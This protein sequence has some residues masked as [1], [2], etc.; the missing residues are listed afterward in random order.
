MRAIRAIQLVMVMTA[1]VVL[2]ADV[3]A[4]DGALKVSPADE[5]LVIDPSVDS[6]ER[7]TPQFV[8][9]TTPGTQQ[10]EIPPTVIIHRYYYTGNRSFQG[11]ML[12]GGPSV[13]VLNHPRTGEQVSVQAQ[14]LP[15]APRVK[16]TADGISYDYGDREICLVFSLLGGCEPKIVFQR[17]PAAAG[18]LA[19]SVV[20]AQ[21]RSHEF[22]RRTGLPTLLRNARQ[23]THDGFMALGDRINDLGP[24]MIQR[25]SSV[26]D[27]SPATELLT[28]L[29]E[30]VVNSPASDDLTGIVNELRDTVPAL[31]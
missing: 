19:E 14:L 30:G 10:I 1:A 4:E 5:L 9:G 27:S 20:S 29:P 3:H 28:P 31:P 17:K 25:V 23:R 21:D 22:V 7:P 26:I 2:S 6:R 8:P 13:L 15:G 11:P 16:Y 18:R 12:P 24:G